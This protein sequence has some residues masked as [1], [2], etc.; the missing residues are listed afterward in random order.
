MHS[1]RPTLLIFHPY[2]ELYGSDRMVATVVRA[3]QER[4]RCVVVLPADGP[5]ADLVRDEGADVRFLLMPV[6]R[7]ALLAPAA[8]F[9]F[10]VRSPGT[11]V[12]LLRLIREIRPAICYVNTIAIPVVL[13]A[14]R[15][16]GARTVCHTHEAEN[17]LGRLLEIALT[18]PLFLAH[19][20]VAISRTAA[21]F[22]CCRFPA[23]LK[24]TTVV[25]NCVPI[26]ERVVPLAPELPKP[27]RMVLLGRWSER[28]GTD[29]AIAA[30]ALLRDRGIDA[31]LD[32]VGGIFPGYE[33]FEEK[34]RAQ[35]SELG[36]AGVVRFV[37]FVPDPGPTYESAD[38]VLVPSRSEPFG[39]VAAEGM[40]RSRVVVAADVDGLSEIMEGA[41]ANWTFEPG[42]AD[43]L[44]SSIEACVRDWPA[45]LVEA[46]AARGRIEARF[47]EATFAR[48]LLDL[49]DGSGAA[50]SA[51]PARDVSPR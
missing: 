4:Y 41:S 51:V 22:T 16:S 2:D 26:P 40:S 37:P 11:V 7:K 9:R 15:L 23:L 3:V 10:V 45:S 5:L 46:H 28:K 14:C 43:G 25:Y 49:L 6:V 21:R 32:V 42:S 17:G 44:A 13:L 50:V 20:I 33:W 31:T 38:I 48:R 27:V 30:A 47:G 36:L 34:I 39:L 29:L 24:R 35:S 18:A 12:R 19:D 1:P 8:L